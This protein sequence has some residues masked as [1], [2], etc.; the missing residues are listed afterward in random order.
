M[1]DDVPNAELAAERESL[2]PWI[3]EPERGLHREIGVIAVAVLA[4]VGYRL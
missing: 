3:V 4:F 1:D 2:Q